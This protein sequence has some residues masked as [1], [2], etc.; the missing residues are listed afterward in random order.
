MTSPRI[1]T[2]FVHPP[3]PTPPFWEAHDDRLGADASPYGQGKT[4]QEA[5]DDLMAQLE[6]RAA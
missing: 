4:E 6:D 3:T 5:I 2:A 1:T